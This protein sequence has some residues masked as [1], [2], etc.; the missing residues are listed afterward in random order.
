MD[1]L[2]SFKVLGASYE[3]NITDVHRVHFFK[4]E[5]YRRKLYTNTN[6]LFFKKKSVLYFSGQS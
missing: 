3:K 1:A 4:C 6:L 2:R 5:T